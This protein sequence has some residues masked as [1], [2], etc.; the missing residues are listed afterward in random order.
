MPFEVY[1][2]ELFLERA[3]KLD[4]SIV[5]EIDKKIEKLKENPTA[6]EHRMHYG[7]DFFRIYVRNMRLVYKVEGN[8]ITLLDIFK[9]EEGY[10]KFRN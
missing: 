10:V 1:F 5:L 8:K 9:R 3:K 7:K 2:S 4:K 6:T